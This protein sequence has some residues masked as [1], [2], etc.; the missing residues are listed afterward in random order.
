LREAHALADEALE[1]YEQWK[2]IGSDS[3]LTLE[4]KTE[5]WNVAMAAV[6]LAIPY[7]VAGDFQRA[8]LLNIDSAG[9]FEMLGET[10]LSEW[11][12]SNIA[13]AA[14]QRGDLDGALSALDRSLSLLRQTGSLFPTADALFSAG[15][16]A[17]VKGD[18]ERSQGLSVEG[19]AVARQIAD[20]PH[21]CGCLDALAA[22]ARR[23][24]RL[25]RSARLF[26]AA[27]AIVEA[28]GSIRPSAWP[29]MSRAAPG[30]KASR[31]NLEHSP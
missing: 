3:Q 22:A 24:G 4:H 16:I 13:W 20:L 19:L 6:M 23:Q 30:A 7:F 5:Q 14:Y 21:T 18:H 26:A 9:L 31:L 8:E 17:R 11:A 1:I 27:K 10:A 2:P 25:H 28:M 12:R 15:H 29:W